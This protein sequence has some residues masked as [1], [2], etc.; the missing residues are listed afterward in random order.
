MTGAETLAAEEKNI[1]RGNRMKNRN[2]RIGQRAAKDPT[3]LILSMIMM[4]I[5]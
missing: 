4:R 5:P 2:H 1:W 3:A